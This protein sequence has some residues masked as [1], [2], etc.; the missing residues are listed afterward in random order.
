MTINFPTGY[1]CKI[2]NQLALDET[3]VLNYLPAASY[4][5]WAA[6]TNLNLINHLLPQGRGTPTTREVLPTYAAPS[7]TNSH[8]WETAAGDDMVAPGGKWLSGKWNFG[9]ALRGPLVWWS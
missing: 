8:G 3:G 5:P 6:E 9:A 4:N 7:P 1:K 2:P